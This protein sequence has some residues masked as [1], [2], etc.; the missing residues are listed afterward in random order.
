VGRQLDCA[1]FAREAVSSRAKTVP[2]K[3]GFILAIEPIATAISLCD[4]I[5]AICALQ[6][7]PVLK[8][9]FFALLH[10]PT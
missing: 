9:D 4:P 5:Y 2:K 6:F 8:N 1:N 10:Q 3:Q 7:S